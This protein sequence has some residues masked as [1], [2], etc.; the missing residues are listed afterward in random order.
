MLTETLSSI[1][2]LLWTPGSC[3]R[4]HMEYYNKIKTG[5]EVIIDP[6]FHSSLSGNSH[7]VLEAPSRLLTSDFRKQ[8]RKAVDF[9]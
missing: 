6:P 4:H 8:R 5:P 2:D 7:M 3:S 9:E 1:G